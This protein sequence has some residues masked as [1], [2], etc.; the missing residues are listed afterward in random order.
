MKNVITSV[1]TLLPLMRFQFL[2]LYIFFT[3]GVGVA[4]K[5]SCI[6][7]KLSFLAETKLFFQSAEGTFELFSKQHRFLPHSFQFVKH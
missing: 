1:V 4:F 7:F 2:Y 6:N 3:H 5:M